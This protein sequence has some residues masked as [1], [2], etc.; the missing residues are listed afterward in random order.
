MLLVIAHIHESAMNLA[1]H[2]DIARQ[3]GNERAAIVLYRKAFYLEFRVAIKA[4]AN[5]V[6]EP[7]PS[8]L[9]RSAASLAIDCHQLQKAK[10]LLELGIAYKPSSIIIDDLVSLHKQVVAGI[11]QRVANRKLFPN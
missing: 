10:Y 8:V 3:S 5:K 9:I 4:I 2:A 1:S 11:K 6:P 7:T